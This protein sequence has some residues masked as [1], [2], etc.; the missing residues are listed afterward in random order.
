MN[1][2]AALVAFATA[3]ASG[4]DQPSLRLLDS[5]SVSV[6]GHLGVPVGNLGFL[7][8][9]PAVRI[10]AESSYADG[11]RAVAALRY[12]RITDTIGLHY[13]TA[14]AGLS[15]RL[16]PR[17]SAWGMLVIHY[18]RSSRPHAPLLQLDGGES[19]FGTDLGLAWS[20]PLGTVSIPPSTSCSLA[21]TS[22]ASWWIWSGVDLAWRAW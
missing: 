13:A 14:G 20:I 16:A 7:P 2:G 10:G 1:P 4:S 6:G 17:L 21:F 22:P 15:L 8:A 9:T 19:E 3:F 18:A 11:V 5:L 12:A